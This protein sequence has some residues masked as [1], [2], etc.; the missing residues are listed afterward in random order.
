M[1]DI[2]FSNNYDGQTVTIYCCERHLE[3]HCERQKRSQYF[4]RQ[5][6]IRKTAYLFVMFGSVNVCFDFSRN[7]DRY[8]SMEL[9]CLKCLTLE[10][11]AFYL[12]ILQGK[13]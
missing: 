9:L 3:R 5:F 11:P 13:G 7:F 1:N 8:G 10:I 6:C 4:E 12:S 2:P